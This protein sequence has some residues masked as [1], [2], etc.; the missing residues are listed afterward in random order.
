M[1]NFA[2]EGPVW[3][4]S[5]PI[6]WSFESQNFAQDTTALF[7]SPIGFAY[8]ATI[9]RAMQTWAAIS[10][11]SLVQTADAVTTDIRIGFGF[12][13]TAATS[14]VG[15]TTWHSS[16]AFFRT[17]TV[18]QLED[19]NQVALQADATG[20]FTYQGYVATLFQVAL[21]EIGHA[22]G[23]AHSTDPNAVMFPTATTSNSYFDASDILGINTLYHQPPLPPHDVLV[24]P[25]YYYTNYTD[26]LAAGVSAEAHYHANGWHEGRNPDAYFNTDYYLAHN[27]DVQAAGVDPLQHFEIDGWREGRDPSANFS[28]S[29]YLAANPDVKAA[30]LDPLAHFISYGQA[31]GRAAFAVAG[32]ANPGVDAAFYYRIYTDVR[33]AGVD[34]TAHYD[35]NGWHEGR[36]PD[37]FF[38]TNYYLAHNPDVAA[39]HIDPLL[40]Y[41]QFGWKE[42]RD[43]SAQFS[44]NKY[45][46]AYS[47]VKAAG[48]DPLLHF[49]GNGQAE[50]R[51]AFGA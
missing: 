7:T 30:G 46:A 31:E 38:D 43:P 37:A 13:N 28:L 21:H 26:V 8:Q 11:L 17:D 29:D 25:Y 34:A 14:V 51:T 12:L 23:L 10:G 49:L 36:N 5:T 22:L 16:G 44:T 45:L 41:E 50:G 27:R 40:H 18:I 6:T 48:V 32:P 47:D 24:D 33:A 39:A 19:P 20:G 9:A 2:F 42:G 1:V 3:S 15:L 35:T 4:R